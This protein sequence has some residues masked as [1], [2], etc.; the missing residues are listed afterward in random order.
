MRIEHRRSFKD[1]LITQHFPHVGM[2]LSLKF[3]QIL[4]TSVKIQSICMLSV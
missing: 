4:S 3:E 2:K 1:M